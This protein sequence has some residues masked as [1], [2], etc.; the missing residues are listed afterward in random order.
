MANG[1]LWRVQRRF[2]LSVLRDFGFGKSKIES[3]IQSELQYI[4][5]SISAQ[6]G[7]PFT[8]LRVFAK[9]VS[10]VVNALVFDERC[11]EDP[12]FEEM[13]DSMQGIVMSSPSATF[14]SFFWP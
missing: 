1:D 10:N 4:R 11:S 14:Y 5:E 8:P 2:S 13:I 12:K 9:G 6:N 7:R 3:S